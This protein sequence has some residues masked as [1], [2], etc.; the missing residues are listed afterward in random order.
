MA[1]RLFP[2]ATNHFLLGALFLTSFSS[3]VPDKVVEP[4]P[5]P[6]TGTLKVVIRPTW[7]GSPFQ[8]NAVY[9]NVNDFR[10]KVE[11]L[12]FYLGEVRLTNGDGNI[13]AKNIEIFDL[14]HNGDT[15]TW[16]GIQ[17]G[18]YTGLFAGLGVPQPLNDADPIVYPPGHPLD[19]ARGTYWNWA[20]A[21]RFL[22]FDGR[23]DLNPIGEFAPALPFSM[24]TGM[25]VCYEEFQRDLPTPVVVTVGSTT[26]LVLNMAIDRFFYSETDTVNLATENQTHGSDPT[27]ALALELTGNAVRS[28]TIE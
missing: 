27:H 8:M 3:C 7:N 11:G 25:N 23:Y 6:T 13:T 12:V 4:I 24:H 28:I 9:N 1:P 18:T 15:V 2:R 20:T 21:Y 22:Q 16:N 26:T 17:P 5:P 10:V 19:L 14:R